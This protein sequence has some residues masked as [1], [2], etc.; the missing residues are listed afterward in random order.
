MF[1]KGEVEEHFK[2]LDNR[3]LEYEQKLVNDWSGPFNFSFI[4]D[5]LFDRLNIPSWLFGYN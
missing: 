5:V 3:I 4:N 2:L 1:R